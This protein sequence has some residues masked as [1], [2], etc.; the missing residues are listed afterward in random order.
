MSSVTKGGNV[1]EMRRASGRFSG[2]RL[3]TISRRVLLQLRHDRLFLALSLLA[4]VIMVL[5]LKVFFDSMKGP[6]FVVSHFIVPMGAFLIHFFTYI[7]CA[8]ALVRERAH[9]TL[10]RMF[11]NGFRRGEIILGFLLAYSLLATLQSLIVLALLGWL[12]ELSYVFEIY[13]SIYLV[14]WLL[15]VISVALGIFLSNFAHSEA[16]MIP[17]IPL[18][19]L[20]SVFL[21]GIIVAVDKLPDWVQPISRIS[22]LYYANNALQKLILPNGSLGD[23]WASLLGLL[24]YGLIV[25]MLGSVTLKERD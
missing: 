14:I 17:T 22:P 15:A 7:L 12:F 9:E 21:S 10:S 5:F 24:A 6:G 2:K 18:V 13:A 20:P 11:V 25:L 4:P 1:G 23:D 8:I 19:I 3:V 16:Q